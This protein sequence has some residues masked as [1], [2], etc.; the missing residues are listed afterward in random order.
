LLTVAGTM[1]PLP[2]VTGEEESTVVSVLRSNQTNLYTA[3]IGEIHT[4]KTLAIQYAMG[5]LR[6][7][8]THYSDTKAGSIEGLLAKLEEDRAGRQMLIDL[9]EWSHLFKKAGIDNASFIDILNSGYN[10]TRYCLTIARGRRVNL[11]CALTLIGGIVLEN[12][13][14]CFGNSTT[15]GFHDRFLF[16]VCPTNNPFQYEPFELL[17]NCAPLE[18]CAVAVDP[19]VWQLTKQWNRDDPTL[20]RSVEVVVRC[21]SIVASFDGRKTL[22]A[23]DVEGMRPFLDYQSRCRALITPNP[24]KTNDAQMC[25]AILAWLNRHAPCG[26][27]ITVRALKKGIHRQLDTLG[28]AAFVGAIKNLTFMS[29]IETTEKKSAGP[30]PSN[31]IRLVKGT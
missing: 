8:K 28:A 7:P 31:V 30:R 9:D 11:D 24:G 20:G 29:A 2:S 4:G 18:P 10:K 12:V 25:N 1:V 23:I 15:G 27:W 16:G 3:L 26:E 6:L 13:Q 21:A 19:D 14:E 5:Q 22:R 17:T